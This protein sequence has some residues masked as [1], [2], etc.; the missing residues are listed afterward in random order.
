MYMKF[1]KKK[2]ASENTENNGFPEE[3]QKESDTVPVKKKSHKVRNTILIVLGS[4]LL[5]LLLIWGAFEIYMDHMLSLI[6]Y[7]ISTESNTGETWSGVNIDDP[8]WDVDDD[9]QLPEASDEWSDTESVPDI[10]DIEVSMPSDESDDESREDHSDTES[11]TDTS[12]PPSPPRPEV[13]ISA[14]YTIL[15]NLFDDTPYS[16]EYDSEVINILLIGADTNSGQSARSDTMILMSINNTKKRIVFTSFM[17]DIYVGIN[18]YKNNRL[19]AAYAAGGPKLLM[20]TI[21]KNFKI[22]IDYY[23]TVNFKSFRYAIDGIGGL[24]MT[25]NENN[26]DYFSTYKPETVKGL[27]KAQA[28]DGTHKVVLDGDGALAYARNRSLKGS[29]FTRTLHQRDLINQFVSHC[30][31]LSLGEIHELLTEVLPWV[32]TNIPKDMLKMMVRNVLTY[33]SYDVTDMR[34]PVAGSFQN[35]NINGRAVLTVDFQKNIKYLFA[36]IYG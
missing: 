12:K 16:N 17:R 18:G 11:K 15:E 4:I 24:E 9:G 7:D 3:I 27:T 29:D 14:D 36:K 28:I 20:D 32:V 19:N 1:F 6:S 35:A 34:V 22:S 2:E 10:S 8:S 5:L 33:L 26:Y 21:E 23:A 30:T 13:E 31:T 25:I